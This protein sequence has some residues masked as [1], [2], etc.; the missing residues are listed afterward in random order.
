MHG[1]ETRA[2]TLH[3][4]TTPCTRTL[5][6]RT[7]THARHILWGALTQGFRHGST[8]EHYYKNTQVHAKKIK[9]IKA[10][11]GYC[12]AVPILGPTRRN[13]FEAGEIRERN[14]RQSCVKWVIARAITRSFSSFIGRIISSFSQKEERSEAGEI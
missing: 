13:G 2:R 9:E 11:I 3:G 10:Q 7:R 14:F 12:G 4:Y 1:I 6:V 8:N 5:I